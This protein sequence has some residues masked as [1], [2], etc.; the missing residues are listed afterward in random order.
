MDG[1]RLRAA[2]HAPAGIASKRDAGVGVL[3]QARNEMAGDEAG[4]AG[5]SDPHWLQVAKSNG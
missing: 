1:S 5:N 2:V 3:P 4:G